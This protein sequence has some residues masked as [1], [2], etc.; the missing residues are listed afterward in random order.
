MDANGDLL[1]YRHLMARPEYREVWGGAY[2]KELGRLAQG[3]PGICDGTDTI[4]FIHKNEVP[5]D[6]FKDV[7]YGQI[8]CNYRAE[9]DDPN[10]ARLVVGGDR[11]NYPG[12]V[13][14]P[15]CDMLT[16]KLLLNSVISTLGA[17][18]FT[19]DI[20]NFYLMTPL[21]RHEFLRL[22]LSDMPDNVIEHY[23]LKAK[24]TPDGYVYV[25][26]K[27]GMYGLPQSGLLA[28]ELLEKRLNKEGYFQSNYT[29]GFW[30]H[31]TRSISFT[32]CVDDFGVKYVNEEDKKHLLDCL[33]MHYEITVEDEGTR[34]LGMTLE[35]DYKN[36]KVHL[37]IPGY[38]PKAL[39]RFN[40]EFPSRPQHQP[41]PHVP[42][43]YGA[44]KQYAK[45]ADASPLLD[46]HGKKYVMQV[47]GTF[48][49]YARAI[50]STMLP[51]LSAI[52]SQ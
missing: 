8:V 42:P 52:V 31:K 51:A 35:W 33:K 5:N 4:D 7:T 36:R 25:R 3:L 18:F 45:A 16:V 21:P 50:D 49:F 11:I 30:T 2:G 34:Y 29:P 19:V 43:D 47:T 28:Q 1:Q 40:H 22:K 44:K 48:L 32:L 24:A 12:E 23:G 10:R 15:T 39:K 37:S 26:C 27:R 17:K 41:Y 38:V 46:K 13:G 20:K 6:R 14:T 9:K